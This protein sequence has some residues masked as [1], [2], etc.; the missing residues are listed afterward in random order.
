MENL[1]ANELRIGNYIFSEETNNIQKITG[2]TDE[3]PFINAVT[4][5]YT[6]YY[7]IEPIP[8]TEKWLLK[9]NFFK[10]S[11][12]HGD[13]LFFIS[14]VEDR[15]FALHYVNGVWYSYEFRLKIKYVHELQNLYHTITKEELMLL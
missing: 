4:F 14:N 1:R 13:C 12:I 6:T 3:N 9:F 8:L 5:D 10:G 11:D 7:E 2:L 15:E